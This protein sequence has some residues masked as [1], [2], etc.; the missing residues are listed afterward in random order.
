MGEIYMRGHLGKLNPGYFFT[1][2]GKLTY[3]LLLRVVSNL[4][5]MAA[6]AYINAWKTCKN[7]CSNTDMAVGAI[8][9]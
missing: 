3:F 9:P 1:P 2:A 5:R 8:Q 6:H 4:G 7:L